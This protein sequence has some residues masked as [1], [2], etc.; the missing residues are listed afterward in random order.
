MHLGALA[1]SSLLA[2]MKA[3]RAASDDLHPSPSIPGGT[4]IAWVCSSSFVTCD[5]EISSLWLANVDNLSM[6]S[7]CSRAAYVF[8]LCL[9]VAHCMRKRRRQGQ[10]TT[11]CTDKPVP[12]LRFCSLGSQINFVPNLHA[13]QGMLGHACCHLPSAALEY[14][15]GRRRWL[16]C[17]GITYIMGA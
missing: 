8:W 9:L 6:Q 4:H 3:S 13:Y 11:A 12:P 17:L 7:S 16:V 10:P 14:F 15:M 2:K 5:P 1:S